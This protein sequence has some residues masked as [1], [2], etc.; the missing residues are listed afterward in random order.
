M[1]C[2]ARRCA[3]MRRAHKHTGAIRS[4]MKPR[5]LFGAVF[6]E[7]HSFLP[8]LTTWGSFEVARGAEILAKEGDESPTAGFLE[9]ARAFGYSVLPTLSAIG[10]PG[11]TVADAAFEQIWQEFAR[12]AEPH[13]RSGI[14]AIYLVLHGAMVTESSQDAEGEFLARVRSLHGAER[15]P[16]FGV[17]DLHANVS[18]RMCTLSNGLVAYRKNP[19]TDAKQAAVRATRLL[20]RCLESK[21]VPRMH[22]CRVPLLLAPPGTGTDSSP[23]RD[24]TQLAE[25]VEQSTPAVWA[26]NVAAG[27]SF[28][29][30]ADSGLT[31]SIVSDAQSLEL[32][33]HLERVAGRAWDLRASGVV[34]YPSVE[35]VLTTM[36]PQAGS[37]IVL[38]E[39]ADNIG[40]GAPGDG[41]GVLRAF[42][43]Q[44]V[45]RALLALN[46]PESVARLN[47]VSP[48]STMHMSLGGRGWRLDK[49][50]VD[51]E[52]SLVSRGGGAFHL[53]DS[54]SHL[55]SVSGSRFDMGACAVVRSAGVTILLT[56]HRTPP[57][58]LG[59]YRSQ[60]IHPEQFAWIGVK[61]AV[62]HRRAYDPIASASYFVDTPGPCSS[63]LRLFPYRHLR[64]P[65][66]PLD[67]LFSPTLAFA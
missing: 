64:R 43:A 14:D 29:D 58:D 44:R 66:Y 41:T 17:L 36:T 53:E 37:P 25:S 10:M 8:E 50:P 5:V 65:V 54:Q 45:G 2:S 24:L 57:F 62:A 7:T 38:V 51:T 6:H 49:G 26:F 23:M 46:D 15:V 63:N 13:L 19:H 67:E 40:A 59:Q 39:P 1:Y 9:T 60:G 11:G 21:R 28:A 30:T 27:F 16:I 22:W 52:V 4:A 3:G 20:H 55:A 12:H 31:F 48:G 61:A 32:R 18:A 33:P 56:S 47:T 34:T 35:E 42:L